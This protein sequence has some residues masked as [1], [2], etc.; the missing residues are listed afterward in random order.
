MT[1]KRTWATVALVAS[2]ALS[3]LL[4]QS[5]ISSAADIAVSRD[6]ECKVVLKGVIAKGDFEK[7]LQVSATAFPPFDGESSAPNTL[8]LDS[9]GGSL[10]EGVKFAGHF[11]DKGVGTVIRKGASCYS[12]CAIMFMLGTARGPEVNF[13]SRAMHS[14]ARLGFHRPSLAASGGGALS[15]TDLSEA[16]DTTFAAAMELLAMANRQ[17]PLT[18][19]S[20]MKPDL[21]EMLL[22]HVGADFFLVDTIDKAG[23]WD[24]RILDHKPEFT[25]SPQKAYH[26]CQN[27][28]QWRTGLGSKLYDADYYLSVAREP[29]RIELIRQEGREA[30]YRVEGYNSG[31]VDEYC[32]ISFTAD[33]VSACGYSEYYDMTVGKGACDASDFAAKAAWLHPLALLN[34]FSKLGAIAGASTAAV[35][36]SGR[37]M[38]RVL[39]RSG[40]VVDAE[41]CDLIRTDEAGRRAEIYVWPSGSRTVVSRIGT[42]VQINGSGATT[43][44]RNDFGSCY[45]NGVTGNTFC[46]KAPN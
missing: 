33:G 24:I 22:T 39:A 43:F 31:L 41:E 26:A 44:A 27:T 32:I 37:S 30:A 40:A 38:C 25:P 8:C 42:L 36:A 19:N 7:F 14:S 16:V 2:V 34:P 1:G 15:R 46:A 5:R 6:D 9:P 17:A 13:V 4:S 10:S 11:Y 21:L 18:A 20:M 29:D 45:T 12:A 23:R 28:I 3:M 35:G